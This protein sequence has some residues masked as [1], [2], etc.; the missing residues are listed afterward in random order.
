MDNSEAMLETTP[1]TSQAIEAVKNWVWVK[2]KPP[3]IGPQALV[4]IFHLPGQAISVPMWLTANSRTEK[5]QTA[6]RAPGDGG[7]ASWI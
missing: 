1:S 7:E 3:G 6:L 4:H 5:E 2:M